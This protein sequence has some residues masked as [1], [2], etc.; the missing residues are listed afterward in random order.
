M[1]TSFFE[2]RHAIVLKHDRL[3]ARALT[4]LL[5]RVLP[6]ARVS[7][8][9]CLADARQRLAHAPCN[10]LVGGVQ[11][12]DGDLLDLLDHRSECQRPPERVLVITS[13][14]SVAMLTQLARRHVLGVFDSSREDPEDL[15]FAILGVSVGLTCWSDHLVRQPRL[16]PSAI[17]RGTGY[18]HPG[19][20]PLT[21][22]CRAGLGLVRKYPSSFLAPQAHRAVA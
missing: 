1:F 6:G 18:E 19:R 3:C 17:A 10:L 14:P 22:R 8:V 7:E 2:I 9:S 5:R 20:L 21:V 4:E 15:P 12:S 16:D 11:F 13:S